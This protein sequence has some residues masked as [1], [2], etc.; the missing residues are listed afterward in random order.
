[1]QCSWLLLGH[2]NPSWCWAAIC[3]MWVHVS[4]CEHRPGWSREKDLYIA[5]CWINLK[6]LT[7]V[8]RSLP[9]ADLLPVSLLEV[10]Q[11]WRGKQRA[12]VSCNLAVAPDCF[13][14]LERSFNVSIASLNPNPF[15]PASSLGVLSSDNTWCI[16]HHQSALPKP[17][18]HSLLRPYWLSQPFWIKTSKIFE[19]QWRGQE[20]AS[21]LWETYG[22]FFLL[23][24]TIQLDLL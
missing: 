11:S 1:M 10:K 22:D 20:T 12:P 16:N 5:A 4:A 3:C 7:I 19:V 13:L 24:T 23:G 18:F 8:C 2:I 9:C 15:K 21:K 6:Q 17:S 14:R